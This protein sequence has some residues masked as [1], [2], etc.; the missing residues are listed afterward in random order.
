MEYCSGLR[1]KDE[2]SEVI[3]SLADET[4]STILCFQ[5][6]MAAVVKQRDGAMKGKANMEIQNLEL[7][8]DM[9]DLITITKLHMGQIRNL[10][11]S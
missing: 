10:G 8:S 4:E 3:D 5:S 7:R 6:R 2:A 9:A 1:H 11:S